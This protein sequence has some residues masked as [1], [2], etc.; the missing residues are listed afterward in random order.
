MDQRFSRVFREFTL[1]FVMGLRELQ[2]EQA[3][4]RWICSLR[5]WQ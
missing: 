2:F 1:I 5:D 3:S 4:G